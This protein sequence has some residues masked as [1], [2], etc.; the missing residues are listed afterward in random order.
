[1]GRVRAVRRSA[2]WRIA[3]AATEAPVGED[4]LLPQERELVE[5]ATAGADRRVRRRAALRPASPWRRSTPGLARDAGAGW[6]SHGAPQWP[7]GSSAASPT[8]RGGPAPWPPA[9]AHRGGARRPGPR[10]RRRAAPPPPAGVVEVVAT[11][12]SATRWPAWAPSGPAAVGAVLFS[13]KEAAYK[14]WYPLTGLVSAPRRCGGAVADGRSPG[15][16]RP[17]STVGAAA[18]GVRARWG[19]RARVVVRR[20]VR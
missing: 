15:R 1:M 8:A 18:A 19:V 7:A 9:R 14:A 4:A 10:A 17:T 2:S 6:T 3:L 5:G 13:A 11:S 12:R 20:G 16:P